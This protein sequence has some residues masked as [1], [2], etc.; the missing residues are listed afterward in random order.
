MVRLE[1]S[2]GTI[3][4]RE[5]PPPLVAAYFK[6]DPRTGCYRALAIQYR[7]LKETLNLLG[8]ECED[9]VLH[10]LQCYITPQEL[11][12]RSYQREALEAWL[13]E[14]RGV[15]SL[16]TGTGKTLIA[17]AAVAKLACPT[18]IVVPTI[19]L[20]DQWEE[21]IK[22]HLGLTPGRYGG[23]EKKV[24]CVTVATYDSAY[25]NVEQLGDKFIMIVFD[26]VHHL[27]SPGYRQI[28]EL[29]A[30]PWRMGLTATPEREDGLHVHLPYLVGPVVYRRYLS[31]MAGKWL[32]EFDIIRV[33]AHMSKGEREEYKKFST[34]YKSFLRKKG[35]KMRN[36]KDFEKLIALSVR[37]PEARE[38]LLAW[39][40]A[41][42]IALHASMKLDLLRD[43]LAK[44]RDDKILIFAE[45]ADIVRA[46]SSK[47]LIP[48][49]TYKTPEDERKMIMSAFREGKVHALVTSKV[50]EEGVDVP[51][52]NVAIILSGTGSRREFVQRLGRILRPRK[53]KRAV[54][55]EVV[56]A[57]TKE[58]NISQKRGKALKG[59]EDATF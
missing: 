49:V 42:R 56:T 36:Q 32:A 48:E 57:G 24:A 33:Y 37:D 59:V 50:L 1:W 46:I 53:G 17:L 52:A 8:I 18:L 4:L 10:P 41:R 27:P 3:I 51:D 47:F 38:A 14:K 29:C 15:I 5:E 11:Q 54:L 2:S 22:R 6:Y 30:A 43:I 45:H 25:I 26:E 39:F 28:A 31:D 16:P 7:W 19:E 44:H 9:D 20:M 21:G 35:L 34:V 23:G 12:L 58:V 13:E 55:Y 40:R